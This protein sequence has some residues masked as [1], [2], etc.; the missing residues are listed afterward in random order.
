MQLHGLLALAISLAAPLQ[1]AK[2]D[3]DFQ[4]LTPDQLKAGIEQR[5]P[6]AYYI[7]ATKLFE[8][9]ARDEAVFWFYAGQL[10]YRFHLGANPNLSPSGDPALF[11]SL[12]EVVGRPINEYA[13]GDLPQLV[14]TVDKVLG[15]DEKTGNGFTPKA[16]HE[17]A[18]KEIRD[19]LVK[20]REYVKANGD[21]IRAQRKQN[22]LENRKP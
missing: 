17:A 10:R 3:E 22:G 6:A 7:L 4:K 13:F 14:A 16:G 19:G 9:G 15:W 20:M 1:T 8:S 18:L 21:E 2:P 11:A 5:H 12:S